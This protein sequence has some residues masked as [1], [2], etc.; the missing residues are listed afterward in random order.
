MSYTGFYILRQ[1]N[2]SIKY[3][4][5]ATITTSLNIRMTL[6]FGIE[7]NL[8][9]DGSYRSRKL[10]KRVLWFLKYMLTHSPKHYTNDHCSEVWLNILNFKDFSYLSS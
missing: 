2:K 6:L 1:T 4:F 5:K 3:E 7:I 10:K 9:Y 8:T